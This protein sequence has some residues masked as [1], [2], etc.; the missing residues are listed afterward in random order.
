MGR[1]LS[2]TV[3]LLISLFS[4]KTGS[5][6]T[7]EKIIKAQQNIMPADSN[8]LKQKNGV[9]YYAKGNIPVIWTLEIDYNKTVNFTAAD[10]NQLRVL[11]SFDEK[12][13]TATYESYRLTTDLGP[14]YIQIFHSNCDGAIS[15]GLNDKKT[16]IRIKD[17]TYSGCGNYLYD[18]NLNDIW[19]LESINN[20][21]QSASQYSKGLP[22]LAFDL[23]KNKMTGSDGCN[24]ISSS[25]EIKGSRIQFSSFTGTKM[26]CKNKDAEKIF[27]EKLSAKLV[28]YYMENGK[29]ILYLIDDSKLRFKRKD[30]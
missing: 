30:L 19:E 22:V 5:K 20:N 26:A 18:Q 25:I 6:S 21:L 3:I 13:I 8:I 15:V 1:F 17:K 9:D 10:G 11:P 28:S 4:C 23:Q 2:I 27:A 14:V 29:L 12:E 24:N 7:I 16:T